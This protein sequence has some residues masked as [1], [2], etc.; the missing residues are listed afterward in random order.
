MTTPTTIEP[1]WIDERDV[2]TVHQRQ[3]AE[4]GGLDGVRD[5]GLLQSALARPRHMFCY[6]PEVTLVDLA[7]SYAF[8]IAK[9]H[10]FIDGNK[11]T[12]YVMARLFL[13]D[14]GRNITASRED[15]YHAMIAL[16]S[17]ESDEQAFAAWLKKVSAPRG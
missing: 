15:K 2:L 10:P 12:A 13:L 5:L 1:R 8:G 16:A 14:N 9:N 11:R 3:L 7:A 4:H 17:G 6:Q